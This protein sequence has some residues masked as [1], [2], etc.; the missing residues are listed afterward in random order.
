M[1][2]QEHLAILAKGVEAWNA[3]RRENPCVTPDLSGTHL[4]APR[5]FSDSGRAGAD[6][7]GADL[8]RANLS[9]ANLFARPRETRAEKALC[10]HGLV[11]GGEGVV[12][13][14]PVFRFPVGNVP[15]GVRDRSSQGP[16]G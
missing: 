3:W 16:P 14:N 7:V 5:A 8:S 10:H 12:P 1:A 2:N 9:N 4:N 11:L 13:G 6:L 15:P